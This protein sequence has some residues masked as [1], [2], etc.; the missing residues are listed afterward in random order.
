MVM[1]LRAVPRR[2]VRHSFW[3]L[4]ATAAV[5]SGAACARELTSEEKAF[6]DRAHGV[7]VGVSVEALKQTLGEPSSISAAGDLCAARGGR[8]EWLYDSFD[9]SGKRTPLRAGFFSFCAD[10]SGTI[11]AI[12]QILHLA[13][14][15]FPGFGPEL[16]FRL[17]RTPDTTGK[18]RLG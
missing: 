17:V 14:V 11:I 10:Q 13:E 12:F 1:H 5:C 4:V 9:A 8:K 16:R 15:E 3:S 18:V 7:K 2:R 6:Y